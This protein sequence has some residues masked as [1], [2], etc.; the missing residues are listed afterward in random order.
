[1]IFA[2]KLQS[3]FVLVGY[4]ER[5][6]VIGRIFSIH[7][8][9]VWVFFLVIVMFSIFIL[10]AFTAELNVAESEELREAKE[11]ADRANQAK[12]EFLANMSHEI[13][14]PL[15]AVLGM[16]EMILRETPEGSPLKTY[17]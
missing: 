13:R 8:I 6:N 9:V 12:S 2:A 15:N 16:N 7:K 11:D 10:Y 4:V 17:A 14:T 3:N 1:M 5:E